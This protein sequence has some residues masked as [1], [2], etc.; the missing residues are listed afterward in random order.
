[1]TV[2]EIIS[3]E[4]LETWSIFT[5]AE[6]DK[7]IYRQ[8]ITV[9]NQGGLYLESGFLLRFR[10]QIQALVDRVTN[11]KAVVQNCAGYCSWYRDMLR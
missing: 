1:M 9:C 4:P 10:V 3:K 11:C 7:S 6:Q 8:T 5:R 2:F